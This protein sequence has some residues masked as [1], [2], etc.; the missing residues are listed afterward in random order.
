MRE[1]GGRVG[2]NGELCE[3]ERR[4]VKGRMG[5]SRPHPSYSEKG[6]AVTFRCPPK[7]KAV[8]LPYIG[9]YVVVKFV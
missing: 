5:R 9:V 8:P 2:I 6:Q 4:V 1:G 3:S 7:G